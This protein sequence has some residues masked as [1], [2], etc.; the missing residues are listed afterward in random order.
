M[1]VAQG[2]NEKE[3]RAED[4]MKSMRYHVH[5]RTNDKTHNDKIRLSKISHKLQFEI[6]T[7]QF[8]L[9]IHMQELI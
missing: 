4:E 1:R 5:E 7:S 6:S 9:D 8:V 2:G 3:K